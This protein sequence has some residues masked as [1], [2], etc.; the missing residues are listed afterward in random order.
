MGLDQA[1]N[2]PFLE[3]DSQGCA[4]VWIAAQFYGATNHARAITHDVQSQPILFREFRRKPA[5]IVP[6]GQC[7]AIFGLAHR[8]PNM[9]RIG[10]RNSHVQATP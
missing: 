3:S 4:A 7:H 10:R 5:A 8:D 1:R 6:D 2:G 9:L